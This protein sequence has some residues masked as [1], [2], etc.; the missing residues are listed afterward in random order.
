MKKTL[1]VL[2]VLTCMVSVAFGGNI[3][4]ALR[5][6][7]KGLTS[8]NR[9]ER[10]ERVF[11]AAD[12]MDIKLP[13]A[14]QKYRE[15]IPD[16]RSHEKTGKVTRQRIVYPALAKTAFIVKVE[17]I[18]QFWNGTDWENYDRGTI[19]IDIYGIVEEIWEE[20]DGSAWQPYMRAFYTYNA[21]GQN[22]ELLIQVYDSGGWVDF[23]RIEMA[24]NASGQLVEE[25]AY[26]WTG[27]SWEYNF[28]Y[29]YAYN[30]SGQLVEDVGQYWDGSAWINDSRIL[31]TWSGGYAVQDIWQYWDGSAWIDAWRDTFTYD[32]QGN[33]IVYLEEWWDGSAWVID[34]RTT[35]TYDAQGNILTEFGEYWDGSVWVPDY[36]WTYTYDALGNPIEDLGQW[37][38]G[39]AWVNDE[40]WTY[41]YTFGTDVEEDPVGVPT[42][43]SLGNYPNPFNP[44][45]AI[46]F[47]LPGSADV[48]LAVYDLQGVLVKNL[49][50]G[51]TYNAGIH[52]VMWDGTDRQNRQV[53]SG[54]Y[55]YILKVGRHTETRRCL[56]LK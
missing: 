19:T 32:A 18:M 52:R 38:D 48:T 7:E 2:A 1:T 21:S 11:R 49:V 12:R 40:R 10:L 54:I 43:Y 9:M 20:W 45:T 16:R 47:G 22:T 44:E 37:W 26:M 13:E 51:D 55:L 14:V 3:R 41:T 27:T 24:Y 6:H 42:E 30:A 35:A 29:M 4:Q 56:L 39:S 17:I 34:Y 36:R 31:T 25:V 33:L 5:Q 15:R 28:K 46:Q 50:A 8:V 53:P 23:I